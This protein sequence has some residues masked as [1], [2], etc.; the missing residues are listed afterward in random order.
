MMNPYLGYGVQRADSVLK[1]HLISPTT[2]SNSMYRSARHT[3]VS[4]Y[5]LSDPIR[6]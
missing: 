5:T 3:P 4:H 1:L 2:C 6:R